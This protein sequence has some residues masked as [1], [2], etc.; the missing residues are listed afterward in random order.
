MNRIAQLLLVQRN[1]RYIDRLEPRLN[2]ALFALTD[3][4]G[5]LGVQNAFP[6]VLRQSAEILRDTAGAKNGKFAGYKA[7]KAGNALLAVQ[8]LVFVLRHFNK[9]D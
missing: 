6:Q 9:V 4:Y 2:F 7:S 3:V 5:K 8:N 1:A